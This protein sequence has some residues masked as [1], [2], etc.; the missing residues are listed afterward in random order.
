MSPTSGQRACLEDI[1]AVS[2]TRAPSLKQCPPAWRQPGR[3]RNSDAV[4]RT[5]TS[6]SGECHPL[7]GEAPGIEATQSPQRQQRCPNDDA[8]GLETRT[9][10]SRKHPRLRGDLA[11]LTTAVPPPQRRPQ[12]GDDPAAPET[13]M[14]S[15]GQQ[16][17]PQGHATCLK[18]APP[19]SQ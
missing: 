12:L 5:M 1:P 9:A 11:T 19:T 7:R 13:T 17:Q 6:T 15:Q 8:P 4:S 18:G 16:H 3:P 14:P 2:R 10:I